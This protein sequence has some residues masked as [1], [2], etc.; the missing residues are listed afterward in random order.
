MN[1]VTFIQF[2]RFNL[3]PIEMQTK[4][5]KFLSTLP[6]QLKTGS[7]E[8]EDIPSPHRTETTRAAPSTHNCL[9]NGLASP[10]DYSLLWRHQ[11]NCEVTKPNHTPGMLVLGLTS[12]GPF[13]KCRHL[14]L[15]LLI[16]LEDLTAKYTPHKSCS[17]THSTW[18]SWSMQPHMQPYNSNI[19]LILSSQ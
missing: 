10:L 7:L 12:A 18:N 11:T 3:F 17:I 9:H 14:P 13:E 16:F 15:C 8:G 2:Y 5:W 1:A 19:F 6:K 4:P